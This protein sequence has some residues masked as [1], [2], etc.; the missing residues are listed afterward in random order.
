[1]FVSSGSKDAQRS[2][3]S[4]ASVAAAR[5]ELCTPDS[6]GEVDLL[7]THIESLCYFWA[8]IADQDT[9]QRVALLTVSMEQTQLPTVTGRLQPNTVCV[10]SVCLSASLSVCVPCANS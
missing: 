10:L 9:A 2:P 1:M 5:L 6:I 7:V 8:Q 3:S 4:S